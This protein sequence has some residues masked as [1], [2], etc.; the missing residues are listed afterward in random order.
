MINKL[1]M[2]FGVARWTYNTALAEIKKGNL[3]PTIADIRKFNVNSDAALLLSD[4][5][6]FSFVGT[7]PY[8]IRDGAARD[9]VQA[10]KTNFAK[11][12][13]NKQKYKFDVKFRSRKGKSEIIHVL[14]K[15]YKDASFYRSFFGKEKI[16]SAEELPK[17]LLH[18]SLLQ[19]NWLGHYYLIMPRSVDEKKEENKQKKE[20][21]AKYRAENI[22]HPNQKAEK[23]YAS[24]ANQCRI[25]AI[26]PGVRTAHTIYDFATNK[27]IEWGKGDIS[28]IH[29]LGIYA[30]KLKSQMATTKSGNK[31]RMRKALRRIYLKIQ[32]LV[33]EY[34]HCLSKW[35]CE[36]YSLIIMPRMDST[37]MASKSVKRKINSTT[38]RNMM[39]WSHAKFCDRLE[40]KC[41]ENQ[42]GN[43]Q[44]QTIVKF[45]CEDYTSKT[46]GR[47]GKLNEQLKAKK[48]FKCE[49]ANCNYVADRDINGARNILLRYLTNESLGM[50]SRQSKR[51]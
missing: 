5:A 6:K 16:A 28:R 31:N 38:V 46:C 13:K 37:Q 14:K 19:R 51:R 35:L 26:D 44:C 30:D 3:K 4:T 29:R 27:V 23:L 48:I 7:V 17:S 34:H 33:K 11:Q 32:N 45:V 50:Q 47:C 9:L 39:S 22:F 8:E 15:A 2:A 21:A 42:N 1:K 36:N 25:A 43:E 41:R 12:K 24:E 18:D 49:D 40:A 10:Y 20:K